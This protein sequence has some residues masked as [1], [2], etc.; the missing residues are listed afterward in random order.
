M[1]TE[2]PTGAGKSSILSATLACWALLISM[3]LASVSN[4]LQGTL[5]GLR[6]SFEDFDTST[7]GFIMSG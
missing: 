7:T 2:N 6:A 1:S 5:L 4:G 3:A